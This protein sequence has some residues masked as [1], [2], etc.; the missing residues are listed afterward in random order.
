MPTASRY[1]GNRI[2]IPRRRGG[3]SEG[4]GESWVDPSGTSIG[5]PRFAPQK[6]NDRFAVLGRSITDA[7]VDGRR[8]ASRRRSIKSSDRFA[9]FNR[10]PVCRIG[11]LIRNPLC[12]LM[13]CRFTSAIPTLHCRCRCCCKQRRMQHRTH[14]RIENRDDGHVQPCLETPDK[15]RRRWR[16]SGRR[17]LVSAT[18]SKL[19][20]LDGAE[21]QVDR[22]PDPLT[23]PNHALGD[24]RRVAQGFWPLRILKCSTSPTGRALRAIGHLQTNSLHLQLL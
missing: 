19:Y 15:L 12:N 4:V 3:L 10:A 18:N 13:L 9:F 24:L 1:N 2:A 7:A 20:S 5:R 6:A 21:T 11:R 8:F 23:A 22:R 16:E 17:I 14:A